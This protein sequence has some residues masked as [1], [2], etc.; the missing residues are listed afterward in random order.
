MGQDDAAEGIR[1]EAGGAPPSQHLDGVDGGCIESEEILV[2]ALPVGAVVEPDAVEEKEG[3]LAREA[4]DEGGAL[5]VASLLDEDPGLVAQ[6]IGS[7][8][9][10]AALEVRT[11]DCTE[12]SPFGKRLL[13]VRRGR[14][15]RFAL[16]VPALLRLDFR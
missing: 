14:D 12:R 10:Q 3:L 4:A 11:V 8:A 5:T 1:A 2:G 9:R 6:R 13:L 7:G 16:R 15:R